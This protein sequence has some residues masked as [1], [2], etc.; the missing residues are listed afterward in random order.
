MRHTRQRL[1][2]GGQYFRLEPP[3]RPLGFASGTPPH[4]VAPNAY[5]WRTIQLRSPTLRG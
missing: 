1:F 4:P 2:E 3:D 5:D